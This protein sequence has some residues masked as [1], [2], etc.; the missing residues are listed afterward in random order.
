MSRPDRPLLVCI[1]LYIL[2]CPIDLLVYANLYMVTFIKFGDSFAVGLFS[3][4]P[5]FGFGVAM[6]PS[7]VNS[8]LAILAT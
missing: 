6:M 2:L 4:F 1:E 5:G 3:A 7:D 8:C